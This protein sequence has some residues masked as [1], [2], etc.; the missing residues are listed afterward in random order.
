MK[1]TRYALLAVFG[2]VL[3]GAVSGCSGIGNA[4][5][6]PSIAEVKAKFEAKPLDER[7]K[8]INQMS[9]PAGIKQQT[10]KD[11]YAKAGKTPPSDILN[12]PPGAT[13][14]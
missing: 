9:I 12:C 14:H 7:A 2:L 4:P 3:I 6:G 5:A 13:S 11:M 10:I 8:E 1:T